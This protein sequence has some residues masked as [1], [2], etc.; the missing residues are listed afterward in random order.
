MTN[1]QAIDSH[2]DDEF[3]QSNDEEDLY[4]DDD[5]NYLEVEHSMNPHS[6]GL[7]NS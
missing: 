4:C 1:L 7:M 6:F 5:M 3:I 2:N